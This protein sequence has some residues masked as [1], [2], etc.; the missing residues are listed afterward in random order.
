MRE[1]KAAAV[2]LLPSCSP[3]PNP[4]R[5]LEPQRHEEHKEEPQKRGRSTNPAAPFGAPPPLSPSTMFSCLAFV[6]FV[7]LWFQRNRSGFFSSVFHPWLNC[8]VVG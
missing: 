3:C 8:M 6:S 1:A 4:C 7:P 5:W 2:C